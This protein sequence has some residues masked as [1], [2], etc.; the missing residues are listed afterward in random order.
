MRAGDQHVRSQ[1]RQQKQ[2]VEFLALRFLAFVQIAV[3][4]Q[5]HG[6]AGGSDQADIKDRKSVD[7]QKWRNQARCLRLGNPQRRER[8]AQANQ[9]KQEAHEVTAANGNGRH[10]AEGSARHNE[11]WKNRDEIGGAHGSV[12]ETWLS[13]TRISGEAFWPE[14]WLAKPCRRSIAGRNVF[15]T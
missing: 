13:L 4:Q 6:E 9:G 10:N 5:R 14:Y 3:A 15:S 12:S 2:N 8:S 1:R 11:Q 7:N